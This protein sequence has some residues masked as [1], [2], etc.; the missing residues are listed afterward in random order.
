MMKT[1]SKVLRRL[2]VL[3]PAWVSVGCAL[4]PDFRSPSAPEVTQ[5]TTKAQIDQIAAHQGQALKVGKDIPG[6]WWELFHSRPLN[7]LIEQAIQRN[8]S[9]QSAQAVLTTAQENR[10]AKAGE[11]LPAL[12]ATFSTRHQKVSGA[13]FGNPNFQGSVFT[14][15]NASVGVSYTLDVFGALQ[16]ELEGMDAQIDYQRFQ[17]EGAFLSLAGNIV[18]SVIQEASLRE[19]I[20]ATE[21]ILHAFNDQLEIIEQQ[22]EIG[23]VSKVAVLNQQALLD[24]T[25]TTLPPLHKQ[26]AQIRHQLSA[27]V[28][29]IPGSTGLIAQF[30]LEE[31]QLPSELPLSLPSTLVKQ[32]PDIRAQEAVL[33]V[34]SAQIGEAAA[35]IFPDFTINANVST[36]ATTASNLF[37]PGSA[38]W[39]VG[40]AISQPIFHGAQLS[41]Y[42]KAAVANYQQA[43]ADYRSTVIKAFQNVA[44]TLSALEFDNL[45]LQTQT[46]ALQTA[47][48]T[49]ELT[50]SQMQAGAAS[51]LDLLN[52]ERSYQQARIGQIKA[53]ASR[54]ADS[55]ALFQA[56]G[57]GWWNRADLARRIVQEHKPDKKY[58]TILKSQE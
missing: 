39:A 4:G 13:Q 14:L 3:L 50:H 27:L 44:D 46:T 34:A 30:S 9:L 38:I 7:T 29:D 22:F 51:Y 32:R 20:K 19:Q 41:H 48:S 12:D 33:H 40:G 5:M 47:E 43:H 18:T 25:R 42:K 2:V 52:A 53:A 37:M 55:A 23:S 1:S 17:L 56:L 57:G 54:Y 11:L 31:L 10:L 16:R 45:E 58:Q 35:Q 26:L 24:Q 36:I 28:G 8:P 49:L 6:L 21:D 15:Y